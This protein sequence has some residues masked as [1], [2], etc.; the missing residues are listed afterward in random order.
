[1]KKL[2][3]V[4]TFQKDGTGRQTFEII[5]STQADAV[6]NAINIHNNGKTR[7]TNITPVP[8]ARMTEEQR[9]KVIDAEWNEYERRQLVSAPELAASRIVRRRSLNVFLNS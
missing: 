9:K 8:W 3:V 2:F 6:I 1:M 7:V 4:E 5:A